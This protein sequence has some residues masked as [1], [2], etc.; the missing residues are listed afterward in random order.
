MPAG[1]QAVGSARPGAV[2]AAGCRQ[3]DSLAMLHTYEGVVPC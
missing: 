3:D 2:Q 1:V